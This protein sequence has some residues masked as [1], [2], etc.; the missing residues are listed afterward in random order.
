MVTLHAILD[1][2]NRS[3]GKI[4]SCAEMS[5]PESQYKAFRREV[6]NILGRQG[7]ERDLANLFANEGQHGRGKNGQE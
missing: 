4:L 5:M 2:L 7:M 1:L 6:L 3:K